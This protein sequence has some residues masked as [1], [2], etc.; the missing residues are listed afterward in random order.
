MWPPAPPRPTSTGHHL[1]T[2]QQAGWMHVLECSVVTTISGI[3]TPQ[4]ACTGQHLATIQQAR[5]VWF[6]VQCLA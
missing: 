4:P 6:A 5:W 3:S 2:I 1:A